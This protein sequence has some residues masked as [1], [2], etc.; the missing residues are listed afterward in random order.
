MAKAKRQQ[1]VLEEF[2]KNRR[3]IVSPEGVPLTVELAA[4]S[5]RAA[6]FFLDVMFWTGAILFIYLCLAFLI[7]DNVTG[8]IVAG[9][10]VFIAFLIRTTYFLHFELAW[11]GK[12][13]GKRIVGLRVIDRE[14]G[15]LTASA[16]IA[17][18]LTREFE[19][20][21]PL[22]VL[23]S[24][25]S[26]GTESWWQWLSGA[27]LLVLGALPFLNKNRM[28]GGDLIA[29][30]I[31]ISLPRRALLPDVAQSEFHYTFSDKQLMAYG[32][33]ELQVL[34]ELL[35]GAAGIYT[36]QMYAQVGNKI[37]D[38]IGWHSAVP[39][40]KEFKFLQDFYTA[41]RAYLERNQLFGIVKRDKHT[42]AQRNG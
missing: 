24:I 27:W 13:P 10:M 39:A 18:N 19:I 7:A 4:I 17:R 41:E 29:G 31:V 36:P 12:T 22:L 23:L 9:L 21:M 16:V 20:F 3:E 38:K 26:L 15:P 28:R 34:E 2:G 33:Y 8:N 25:G 32:S 37:R 42:E 1:S 40:E 6:A 30:T 11:Q 14:G 35:R 5:E